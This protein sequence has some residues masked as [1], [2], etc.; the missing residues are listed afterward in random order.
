MSKKIHCENCGTVVKDDELSCSTCRIAVKREE[1]ET[2]ET[3]DFE[4]KAQFPYRTVIM[5][6]L[7]FIGMVMAIRGF[8]EWQN[9]E[10]CTAEGCGFED[11]FLAG[12]G[13]IMM[14]AASIELAR[15]RVQ[16][17]VKRK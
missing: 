15:G 17:K 7:I 6:V 1:K 10:E 3:E 12:V 8:V 2:E 16:Y 14:L 11:L 13:V 4:L 5:I 9:I